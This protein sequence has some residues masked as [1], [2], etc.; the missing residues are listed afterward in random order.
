LSFSAGKD[1]P[2]RRTERARWA[3]ASFTCAT[4]WTP[5]KFGMSPP[6]ISPP[7]AAAAFGNASTEARAGLLG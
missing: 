5:S 2:H 7:C 6:K 3:E 4:G 1:R